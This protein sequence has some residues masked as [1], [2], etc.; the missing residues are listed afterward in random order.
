MYMWLFRLPKCISYIYLVFIHSSRFTAPKTLGIYSAVRTMRELFAIL[1]GL[2]FS[3]PENECFRTIKVKWVSRHSQ[4]APLYHSRMSDI[5]DDFWKV[6]KE[7]A[8]CQ[9]KQPCSRDWNFLSYSLISREGTG[10][11]S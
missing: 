6:P 5:R 7:R 4:Q 3:F 2:Q 11:K 1:F 8:G 10:A 9:G